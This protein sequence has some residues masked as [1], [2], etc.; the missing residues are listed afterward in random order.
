MSTDP[1]HAFALAVH[2]RLEH[3]TRTPEIPVFVTTASKDDL[4]ATYLAAFPEGSNPIFRERT[5]HDCS[6]CRQFIKGIGGIVTLHSSGAYQTVWDIDVPGP[7]G[8]V[9]ARMA[10][11]L[12]G[13]PIQQVYRT[14]EGAFGAEVTYEEVPGA[15]TITWRH[16]HARV[17]AHLR[18]AS[19]G[20]AI[21]EVA[22]TH[23][24]LQRGLDELTV[25]ALDTVEDLITSGSLYRGEEHHQALKDF[26]AL[27]LLYVGL[28]EE[29]RANFAW[30]NI[31]KRGARFRNTAIGT[32]VIDISE[33]MD[34]TQAVARFESK[35]AP[36]NYRRTSAPITK[37]MVD[38][39]LT[40]LREL[41]LESAVRRRFA[42]IEDVS[43]NDVLFVDRGVRPHMKDALADLLLD[44][45]RPGALPSERGGAVDVGGDEFIQRIL[46]GASAVELQLDSSHLGNFV[47]LTAPSEP[48]VGR[49]FQWDN[50]FAW[51]Y[52]GDV[53]DSIKQRV[54]AAGGNVSA[55]LRVSLSWSNYD[56][57]DIHCAPPWGSEISFRDKQ[58]ILDVDMNAGGGRS[59]TPVENL[60]F[61]KLVDGTYRVWVN[62]WCRR[63]NKD[64]G[65]EV[66]YEYQG[67]VQHFRYARDMRSGENVEVLTITVAGG[68][69]TSVVPSK[70]VQH[71][72]SIRE[73]WGLKT[74]Q[75]VPVDAVVLSPNHWGPPER[76]HG[77]KHHIFVLRG[78]ANPDR[79][80]G[81][82]NEFLRPE[83]AK[84]RKVFEVLGSKTM[85]PP[86]ERQ[87]SGVGFSSTR[88]DRATFVVRKGDSTRTYTVQF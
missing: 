18:A 5:Q 71:G 20:E 52:D 14:K 4:W 60:A 37:G 43:V 44:E 75:T 83:L 9:A 82:F 13:H 25:E 40:T 73:K 53:T 62:Q 77:N 85:C 33:G 8:V 1:F 19:P 24:V 86:P 6:C 88:H 70:S 65:F 12:R 38:Q 69:V 55:L 50:D 7:H 27:K 17:P 80:R 68:V 58:G 76:R 48:G 84:H 57:L 22:A 78:C 59:R 72:S 36:Q 11:F 64:S 21:G 15:S 41:G 49:L 45:V 23:Q 35:V 42:T 34:V 39:A 28:P 54:K 31:T 16:F 74:G 56:D 26:T 3:L 47:S 30:R 51:V 63:E 81:F 67:D 10:E 61:K 29:Q 32:L 46:P 2:Q 66:E 87:L 79:V